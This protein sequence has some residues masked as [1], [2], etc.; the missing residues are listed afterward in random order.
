M[1]KSVLTSLDPAHKDE[2]LEKL[3]NE[4]AM[5]KYWFYLGGAIVLMFATILISVFTMLKSRD[6]AAPP[7]HIVNSKQ[8][9][10]DVVTLPYPHQSIDSIIRWTQEAIMASYTFTFSNYDNEVDAAGYYFTPEGYTQYLNALE[11]GKFRDEIINKRLLV[12][13]VP[14]QTPVL[15]NNGYYFDTEYWQFGFLSVVSYYGGKNVPPQ[16]QM[17]QV[18]VVRVP[19][20]QN[21][22]GLAVSEFNIVPAN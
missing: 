10:V 15:I 3:E 18:T 9:M 7:T 5:Q 11:A 19:S 21:H 12:S 16:K 22:K 14:I 20:H 1:F 17:V 8:E 4:S 2:V 13:L 6:N